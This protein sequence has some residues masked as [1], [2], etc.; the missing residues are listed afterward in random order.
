[1]TAKLRT[2]GWLISLVTFVLYSLFIKTQPAYHPS[3]MHFIAYLF[4]VVFLSTAALSSIDETA[5]HAAKQ[6]Q[7]SFERVSA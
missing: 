7:N 3:C 6:A 4:T 1:M 5:G 2:H